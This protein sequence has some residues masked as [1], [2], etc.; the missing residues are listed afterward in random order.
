MIAALN[1][2]GDPADFAALEVQSVYISGT[3]I[4][5]AFEAFLETGTLTEDCERHPD[6]RSSAQK[7]LMP[8]LSLKVPVFPL[9]RFQPAV[10]VQFA[11]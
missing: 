8:Q 5:P 10:T 1:D 2:Q 6:F 3:S 11:A 7:R 4:R 9:F